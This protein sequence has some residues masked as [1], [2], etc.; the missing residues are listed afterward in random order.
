ME[1][2]AV[3]E[4]ANSTDSYYSLVVGIAKRAREIAAEA[5]EE[6][7]ILDKKPVQLAMEEY[8]DKKFYLTLNGKCI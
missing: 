2:L 7:K 5:E 4:M 6:K 1:K 3:T 8:Y